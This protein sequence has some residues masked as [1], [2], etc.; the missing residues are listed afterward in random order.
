MKQDIID[1]EYFEHSDSI[2]CSMKNKLDCMNKID[3][4]NFMPRMS[5]TKSGRINIKPICMDCYNMLN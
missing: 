2:N 4:D 1:R 3:I 5:K